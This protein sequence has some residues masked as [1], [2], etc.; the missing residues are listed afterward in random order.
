MFEVGRQVEVSFDA[1]DCRDAWFP[2]TILDI[3]RNGSFLVGYG[4]PKVG[5]EVRPLKVTI[6]PLRVRPCPPLVKSKTFDL[7]EKVD[8]SFDNG[9]WSGVITKELEDS[10]YLV[11]FKETSKN[12]KFHQSEIRP[13]MEWRDGKWI[14]SSKDV[15]IPSS[16]DGKW[17][18]H[19]CTNGTAVAKPVRSSSNGKDNSKEKMETRMESTPHNRKPSPVSDQL[20]RSRYLLP[21]DSLDTLSQPLKKLKEGKAGSPSLTPDQQTILE[22]PSKRVQGGSISP[23]SGSTI[24]SSVKPPVPQ[25]FSSN[26]PYWGRR[27]QRKRGK[28]K[29]PTSSSMKKRGRTQT[30]QVGNPELVVEAGRELNLVENA[31]DV[32]EENVDGETDLGI[33][34][35]LA[36]AELGSSRHKT[37][38]LRGKR[39]LESHGKESLKLVSVL[40]QLSNDSAIQ[41]I[42]E[43][44]Q[45]GTEVNIQKR[46]RG[47]PR[48]ILIN[49]PQ[50]PVTGTMQ[51]VDVL[52][53]EMVTKDCTA[54]EVGSHTSGEVEMSGMKGLVGNQDS[55]TCKDSENLFNGLPKQKN[56]SVDMMKTTFAEVSAKKVSRTLINPNEKNS[57]KRGKRRLADQMVASQFQDTSGE[58]TMGSNG[59]VKE[60]QKVIA[61]VLSKKLDDE[62]LSKWIEGTQAPTPTAF[63]GSEV[64]L[65]RTAGQC[66]GTGEKQNKFVPSEQ[67]SLPFVKNTMLWKTIESMEVFQRMPQNPHFRPLESYKESSREG[68]AVG[69]MVTFSSVVDKVSRLQF[70]DPKSITDDILETLEEL[71]IHGFDVLAVRDRVTGL[72]SVKGRQEKLMSQS[73]EINGQIVE[74]NL[75]INKMDE[76]IGEINKQ[77][78]NL[79]EKLLVVGSTKETKN[80][81]VASLQSRLLEIKE[82]INNVECD[83]EGL[84][85]MPL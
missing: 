32:L 62:P 71:E 51:K 37:G 13:H 63:D 45:S 84:A 68:L 35:G 24:S 56:S 4:S 79:Q 36:C 47:R 29:M 39:A 48:R 38:G 19:I 67:Q 23:T 22:T 34:L 42:K 85:G 3:L 70:N 64:I 2:A 31:A 15:S 57:S 60:A 10:R 75:E 72:G 43:S 46:K 17:G 27:I 41:I 1:E 74:H 25:D 5:D 82:N 65:T 73:E 50:T 7:L 20:T 66:I 81:E 58:K 21:F 52:E 69:Y 14:T 49:S 83:F 40:E 44:K 33:V 30:P 53:D 9:W 6:D 8:A 55:T 59:I 16:E 28:Q 77:I 18:I 78:R 54:N 26:N 80:H 76:E 61:E 12:R 11:F